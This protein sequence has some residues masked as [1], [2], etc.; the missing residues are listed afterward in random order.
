AGCVPGGTD[1]V[2]IVVDPRVGPVWGDHDRLEQVFVNLLEN[3]ARHGDGRSG[4]VVDIRPGSTEG[5]VDVRVSDR[6][7]GIPAD[8]V[9]AVFLPDVRGATMATGAGLG[10]AIARGIVETHGGTI[11]VEPSEV[12]ATLLVTLAVEPPDAGAPQ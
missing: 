2:E 4:I 1:A 8:L 3:A 10:L 7:P 11:S 5:I 6:G 9:D 12:G